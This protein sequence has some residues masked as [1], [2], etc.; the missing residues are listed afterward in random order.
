[1]DIF[2]TSASWR[3]ATFAL[4]AM[5]L[6]SVW[7]VSIAQ[8][9]TPAPL[10]RPALV[11]ALQEGGLI[12]LIRHERT[13]V[14]SRRDDYT[15]AP[16]D[17]TAQRN[18]SI[19]GAAGAQET[20]FSLRA[21]EIPIGRVITSPM[22][23]SA[24]TARFMFGVDYE[25]DLRLMH[26]DPNG[27]R[28]LDIAAKEVRVLLSELAPGLPDSNIALVSHGGNIF[29]VSGLRL[30][31]GEIGV[32]RLDENGTVVAL[33]QLT[34]SDLGFLARRALETAE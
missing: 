25:S 22:C 30:T 11:E 31:E 15:K 5:M 19:A 6:S 13:E 23:R 20:G 14:P 9:T 16:N 8:E 7:P 4:V 34:G 10:D 17:C 29:R 12:L 28:T 24:E 21:L 33:G 27:E 32:L 3:R 1:M 26:H 18:L 2:K